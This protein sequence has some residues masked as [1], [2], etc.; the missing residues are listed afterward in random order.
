MPSI[1]CDQVSQKESAGICSDLLN[2]FKDSDL[3]LTHTSQ[4]LCSVAVSHSDH[5]WEEVDLTEPSHS[6][7]NQTTST[8][9]PAMAVANKPLRP[10]LPALQLVLTT[11]L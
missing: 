4:S 1:C 8:C 10:S 9:Q 7:L 2:P 6:A 11:T 5:Q 3:G